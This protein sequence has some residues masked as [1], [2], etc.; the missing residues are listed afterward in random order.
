MPVEGALID[1]R[2]A[3]GI[4]QHRVAFHQSEF[5]RTD[6]IFRTLHE[7]NGYQENIRRA[8]DMVQ[9]IERSD[10]INR[11]RGFSAGVD[12]QNPQTQRAHQTRRGLSDPA[13][14]EHAA[15]KSPKHPILC[16]LVERS[17]REFPVVDAKPFRQGQR[18]T[19]NM[20]GHRLGVGA[21]VGR[22]HGVFRQAP[23]RKMVGPGGHQLDEPE[24]G[25]KPQILG[26]EFL[27]EIPGDQHP[28]AA[29]GAR[30]PRFLDVREEL[31]DRIPRQ[32]I[33]QNFPVFSFQRV[34]DEN[35][36]GGH[37]FLH[38]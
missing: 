29:N 10:E 3:R 20:L 26:G 38:S 17:F 21:G 31:Q 16:L 34:R 37:F 6:E 27:R 9:I 2:S 25:E 36:R 28:G 24:I 33:L 7:R 11:F 22:Y 4:Y 8:Q 18:H 35:F 30:A 23:E 14:P 12:R 13:K 32:G 5:T 1:Y 15:R 19:E